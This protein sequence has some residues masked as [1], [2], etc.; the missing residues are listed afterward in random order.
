MFLQPIQ[1]APFALRGCEIR[2][3]ESRSEN[4]INIDI[5]KCVKKNSIARYKINQTSIR[6]ICYRIIL[7]RSS[8][9]QL[10]ETNVTSAQ[11]VQPFFYAEP[12]SVFDLAYGYFTLSRCSSS[13]RDHR[14]RGAVITTFLLRVIVVP[15][16]FLEPEA[17][18][19]KAEFKF[20]ARKLARHGTW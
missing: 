15:L 8:V 1:F 13:S 2:T 20:R 12:R 14:Y 7:Y 11:L 3:D 17:L 16:Y 5:L 6:S 9:N 4:F 18:G 19:L 10:R